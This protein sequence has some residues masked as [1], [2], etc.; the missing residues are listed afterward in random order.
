MFLL[1]WLCVAQAQ[2]PA[3]RCESR[4]IKNTVAV[5]RPQNICA[6]KL[7]STDFHVEGFSGKGDRKTT[8]NQ[9]K[10]EVWAPEY[11]VFYELKVQKKTTILSRVMDSSCSKVIVLNLRTSSSIQGNTKKHKVCFLFCF[12]SSQKAYFSFTFIFDLYSDHRIE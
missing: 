8:G 12:L 2:T 9:T 3:S 4:N 7:L 11:D 1:L 6:T 5:T 10:E